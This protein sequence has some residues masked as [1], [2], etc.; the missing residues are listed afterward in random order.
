MPAM[1]D[2]PAVITVTLNAAVDR[3]IEVDGLT[4]GA[5]QAGREVSRTAGGKG[6]N[7]SRT[8][9]ALGVP[10]IATG[11]LGRDNRA[12]FRAFLADPLTTDEFVVLPGRTRE[13]V[14]L[15]DSRTARETHVRDAGLAVDDAALAALTR[16]LSRLCAPGR[17]AV[18][19][20]SLPPGLGPV[21][22]VALLDVCEAAGARVAADTSGPALRPLARKRLWLIKPNVAELAELA[23]RDL[24]ALDDQ[25][26]AARDLLGRIDMVLLSRGAEGAALFAADLAVVARPAPAA[27]PPRNTVGCGDVLLGAFLACVTKGADRREALAR[28]VAAAAAS[29]ASPVAAA[30]DPRLAEDLLAAVE[31]AHV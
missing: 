12:D 3:V 20:G 17:T 16:K 31:T 11:F 4:L 14:T 5:H 9:A 10:S 6:V 1:P 27:G 19:S 7:V 23:G 29:A 26:D 2:E 22:F 30:F 21:Q 8:L 24:P 28:A 13:N 25:A 18:F 15:A